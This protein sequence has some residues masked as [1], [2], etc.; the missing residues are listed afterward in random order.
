MF[1]LLFFCIFVTGLTLIYN[2]RTS[3]SSELL[4]LYSSEHNIIPNKME[5]WKT[6]EENPYYMISDLG[7]VQVI[8]SSRRMILIPDRKGYLRVGLSKNCRKVNR[9]VH[10]LV[11]KAFIPN[12]E[13]KTQINH[14]NSIKDDNRVDNLEWVTH[15]ENMD[16]AV[17]NRVMKYNLGE[18]NPN[19]TLL[20]GEVLAIKQLLR[21]S[22]L[23]QKE[24]AKLFN[25]SCTTICDISNEKIHLENK[26]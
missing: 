20:N 7:N 12:P 11:A 3:A 26:L 4:P 16:H 8:K 5:N 21:Y 18:N 22:H 19:S 2:Q 23:Y 10:R 24:I 17:K 9:S 6:I 25:V 1:K 15:Q 14:K 13:N